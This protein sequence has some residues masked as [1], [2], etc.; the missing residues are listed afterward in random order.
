MKAQISNR[1]VKIISSDFLVERCGFEQRKA[2]ALRV[3]LF[4]T[5][6][7]T[8]AGLRVITKSQIVSRVLMIDDY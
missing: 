1:F 6:G 5:Y 8:L 4:K 2:S 3:Q 7:S